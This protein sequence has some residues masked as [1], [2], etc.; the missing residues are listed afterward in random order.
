MRCVPPRRHSIVSVTKANFEILSRIDVRGFLAKYLIVAG[1]LAAISLAYANHFTN[2]FHFDDSHAVID[3]PYIRNLRNTPLFFTSARAFSVLPA[4]RA[5]RPLVPLSLA[6]DY[7]LGGGLKPVYFQA[8]TFFWY[9]LQIV[10]LYALFRRICDLARPGPYN[11]WIAAFAAALYGLHPAM[12][13]TVNYVI[14]RGDVYSTLGVA[15]GLAIYATFPAL[16]KYGLY[17]IP[18]VAAVLSKPP[19]VIFPAILFVYILLFE[20]TSPLKALKRSVPAL[21][22]AAASGGLV[23]AMTPAAYNPGAVSAFAYRITQPLVALR[24]F[25]TFFVPNHLNADTDF[26]PAAGIFQE[27]AWVGFLFI[28][29]LVILAIWASKRR[30]WHPAAFGLWWFL[31]ALAPTAIFPLAEV[32]NDHRMF[33]PFAG[34]ALAVCWPA[35]LWLQHSAAT[36]RFLYPAA[37]LSAAVL[38]ACSWGTWK[39]NAVWHSDESLWYDVTI[40]SPHNGRG[41]MNYGLTQMA[42]GDMR[43]ALDYFNRAAVYTP[44]YS[45]LEVNLGIANGVVHQDRAAETHYRRAIQLAPAD[46]NSHYYY[47]LWLQQKGRLP[48]AILQL[49]EAV[50]ANPD[51]LPARD[52]LMNAF[53]SQGAWARTAEEARRTLAHFPSDTRAAALLSR[54]ASPRNSTTTADGYLNL[55]LAY[56]RAG[57]FQDSIAAAKK[58]LELKPDCAEAYNNIAA[59]YEEMKMWD[60]AIAAARTAVALRP[61]FTLA[62]NN[63]RWSEAQKELAAKKSLA[64]ASNGAAR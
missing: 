8:S 33:F 18:V 58:A 40:K 41:L 44:N 16:R 63:L 27:Y 29:A 28:A 38:A 3:N 54:A 15:A 57:R 48:E 43:R 62:R 47:G 31:L 64:R 46:V 42:K 61:D 21:L 11:Q 17:L 36:R 51:Y 4:N 26:A 2:G 7:R 5:Y 50:A 60:P 24:Y 9:L 1:L 37:A 30:E 13:E 34:L 25:R 22:T 35:A 39:R 32:E 20:E 56:H 12:A 14:Q 55:S 19:A 52:S 59:A 45:I 23:A 53:V 49:Q 6:V 10:L